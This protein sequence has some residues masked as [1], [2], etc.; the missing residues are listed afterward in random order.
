MELR[1]IEIGKKLIRRDELREQT[2]LGELF[3]KEI[4]L[5]RV[6]G[7]P[8]QNELVDEFGSRNQD[9]PEIR[10]NGE[11]SREIVA[12]ARLAIQRREEARLCTNGSDE[13]EKQRK[14]EIAV[15]TFTCESFNEA[16]QK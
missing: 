7:T 4:H 15:E 6:F 14:S 16:L 2:L 3:Q 12:N 5:V 1:Q 11:E 9:V 8:T 13:V 10:R